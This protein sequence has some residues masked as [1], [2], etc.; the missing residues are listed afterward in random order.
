M[1]LTIDRTDLAAPVVTLPAEAL[2]EA[3][4]VLAQAFSGDPL[5][6]LFFGDRGV[7]YQYALHMFFSFILE[8]RLARGALPLGCMAG[9]RVIGLASISDPAPALPASGAEALPAFLGPRAAG[10]LDRYDLLVERYRPELPHIYLGALGVHP[11]ARAR[12]FGR[13]LLGAVARRSED[14]PIAAGVYLDTANPANVALYKHFGYRV[15][16]HGR[17]DDVELWCM[18]R[19]NS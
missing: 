12:G 13:A 11:R 18:F 8:R 2:P 14:D 7:A 6:R 16:G 4:S 15:V 10:R 9:A 3:A 5:M 1:V 17:L 19:P